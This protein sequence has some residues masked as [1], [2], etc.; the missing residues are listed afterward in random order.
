MTEVIW[1]YRGRKITRD[2]IWIHNNWINVD[3][4]GRIGLYFKDKKAIGLDYSMKWIVGN[5][6][7]IPCS[8][9]DNQIKDKIMEL[10]NGVQEQKEKQSTPS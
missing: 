10:F 2:M 1:K 3:G 9:D 5:N 4:V 7:E 6:E 8:N